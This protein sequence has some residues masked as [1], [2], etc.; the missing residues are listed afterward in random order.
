M[1][2]RV[3]SRCRERCNPPTRLPR[4]A[5]A[6]RR[7]CDQLTDADQAEIRTSPPAAAAWSPTARC[8]RN[9]QLGAG[10][11]SPTASPS[12]GRPG[13]FTSSPSAARPRSVA[14]T[15]RSVDAVQPDAVRSVTYAGHV[16]QTCTDSD[17]RRGDHHA[18]STTPMIEY[19]AETI[20]VSAQLAL[21][22][23]NLGL[24]TVT[25]PPS[26]RAPTPPVDQQ[27][28]TRVDAV[29]D[30][31][32]RST[33]TLTLT[34]RVSQSLPLSASPDGVRGGHRHGLHPER[35]RNA[36]RA[37]TF[38]AGSATATVRGHYPR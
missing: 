28:G 23:A 4:H 8:C 31:A 33:F 14:T 35:W 37:S 3:R 20:T 30:G 17:L 34:A 36:T 19:V 1:D 27:F 24:R 15:S 26:R 12:R 6:G 21:T 38:E 10:H 29:S 25:I 7:R 2:D 22:G 13:H 11:R 32:R 16:L 5:D 9:V 18:Q